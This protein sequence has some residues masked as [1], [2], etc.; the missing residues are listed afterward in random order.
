MG[1]VVD[2][3]PDRFLREMRDHGNVDTACKNAGMLRADLEDLCR[4]NPKFD[5][6]QIECYLEFM[7]DAVMSE[8]RKLLEGARVS[9]VN[10]WKSRH[11]VD[12]HV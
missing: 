4:V 11:G 7:E 2:V 3:R 9:A 1:D 6:A 8:T 10:A 5:R 12:S